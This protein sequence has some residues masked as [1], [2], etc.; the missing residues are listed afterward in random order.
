MRS[1]KIDVAY[2]GP[3][4]YVLASQLAQAEAFAIP[5][6]KKSGKSSLPESDHQQER[7]GSDQCGCRCE[8]RP[9]RLSIQ[10]SIGPF[11]SQRLDSG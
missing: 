3:F 7:Q 11:V 9:L 2:F 1:G 4:S 5:V 8:A 10:L 6:A